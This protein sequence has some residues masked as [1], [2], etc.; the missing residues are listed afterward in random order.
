VGRNRWSGGC[1]TGTVATQMVHELGW[2][3]QNAI[4]GTGARFWAAVKLIST[5][6]LENQLREMLWSGDRRVSASLRRPFYAF[7][8]AR[9]ELS[10]SDRFIERMGTAY[11][12][13]LVI[14]CWTRS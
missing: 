12:L 10:L 7:S 4:G 5:T 14:P 2:N 8:F 1:L 13:F 11:L 9:Y 3:A 6:E